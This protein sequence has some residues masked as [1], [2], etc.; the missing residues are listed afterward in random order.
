MLSKFL[1]LH[2][3]ILQGRIPIKGNDSKGCHPDQ[4]VSDFYRM[5][6]LIRGIYTPKQSNFAL[7]IMVKDKGQYGTEI[8]YFS[9]QDWRIEYRPPV[10]TRGKHDIETLQ[11][12]LTNDFPIGVLRNIKKK[13]Q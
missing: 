12:C 2:G 1:V 3:E 5:H 6:D 4:F 8:T 9:T 10:D 7:S 11:N 13:F